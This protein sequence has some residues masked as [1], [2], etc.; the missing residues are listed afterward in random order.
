[1]LGTDRAEP[2]GEG[3]I[4]LLLLLP[5]AGTAQ[6]GARLSAV[7][8]E[9]LFLGVALPEATS[10][11]LLS[12]CAFIAAGQRAWP[13]SSG[14]AAGS[15]SPGIVTSP[16]SMAISRLAAS[17]PVSCSC[18]SGT[19]PSCPGAGAAVGAPLTRM[20]DQ[21]LPAPPSHRPG[22]G[23]R[24]RWLGR[25]LFSEGFVQDV[26]PLSSLYQYSSPFLA[27]AFCHSPPAAALDR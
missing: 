11:S 25:A 23:S 18:A 14:S 17:S 15:T 21:R 4:G 3:A 13:A 26:S 6:G 22:D 8:P 10:F 20:P 27:C 1:M 5:T 24:P 9:A 16:R 12:F 7:V 19:A 2:A